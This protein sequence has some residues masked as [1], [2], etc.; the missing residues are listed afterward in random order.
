MKTDDNLSLSGREE[1]I[2]DLGLEP[3]LD[4][5]TAPANEVRKFYLFNQAKSLAMWYCLCRLEY[6]ED[7]VSCKSCSCPR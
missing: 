6:T 3:G 1:R 7:L 2:L 5:D 4:T